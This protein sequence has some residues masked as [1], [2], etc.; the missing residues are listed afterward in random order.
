M[1]PMDSAAS[2]AAG[3]AALL[4]SATVARSAGADSAGAECF[5][6]GVPIEAGARYAVDIGGRARPMCCAGCQ[7]VAAAVVAAGLESYYQHRTARP[8]TAREALPELVRELAVYDHPD[9]QRTFVRAEGESVRE[10]WLLL[11]GI[12]CAACM[13]LNEQRLAALPGVMSVEA[14]YATHRLRVRW[15]PSRARLSGILRAVRELGYAA[16]PFDPLRQ[17]QMLEAERRD[18]LR[19]LGVAAVF[20]MQVMMLAVALYA[21]DWYGIDTPMRRFFERVS[22]LL[23]LPVL[24]YAARPFL[25]SA[26][27]DLAQRRVSMDVPV[28]TALLLAFAG[29]VWATVTGDGRVYYDSV[30]MFV[31]LLLGVRYLELGARRR[32]ANAADVLARIE[33]LLARRL[34]ESGAT[35]LVPA[36]E[37]RPEDRIV[38]RA[39]DT[40]AADGVII[41][42]RSS[43]DQSM[44]T[45]ESVP[46]PRGAGDRVIG[47]T[48]NVE[49]PLTVRVTHVG[50]DSVLADVQRLID[51]AQLDKPTV[52]TAA[53]RI[54][55]W[56]VAGV[57]GVAAAVAG[58]WLWLDP[59]RWL[60]V[61]I[62]VLVVSCPCA[63]SLA[64]PT[65]LTAAV[66]RL[67]AAGIILTRGRA[68]ETLARARCF[69]FDKTGTLTD[70]RLR[71]VNTVCLSDTSAHAC[72]RLAAALEQHSEHPVARALVAA[73]QGP[74]PSVSAVRARP[75][76]GLSGDIDGVRV[77][78]GSA[79]YVAQH[80]GRDP[81][82]GSDAAPEGVSTA[83]LATS[84]GPLCVFHLADRPRPTARAL[85]AGL[86]R[87]GNRVLLLS[88][89]SAAAAGRLARHVGIEEVC[90]GLSPEQK[91]TQVS[92]LQARGQVVAM[93]GDGVNDAPVLA[94]ASVSVAVSGAAPLAAVSADVVL[95]GSPLEA[96]GEAVA[97]AR[98]TQRVIR[99]NFAWALGYNLLAVPLAAAGFVVPLLAVVGMSLSSLLVVANAAR[100]RAWRGAR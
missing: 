78:L 29:S 18:G 85:V 10:A 19:R 36:V 56:F 48:L 17:Q 32:A 22:L 82:V 91:L 60:S 26:W 37:L 24:I 28:S 67:R 59:E 65:A 58:L 9:V 4:A 49:A 38:V 73:A 88:G 45:G 23:T 74:L 12:N 63:L 62:A 25:R 64:T 30:V 54:A 46:E 86:R 15:H 50:P 72:L 44:L 41:D 90:A 11:E 96:V 39:G 97:T 89:D 35:E 81:G 61:T 53:E 27:R 71:L 47:G 1:L 52:A 33:P 66:A 77:F 80:S 7:A 2:A 20:G 8:N 43:V 6:C 94:G 57:L 70:G 55:A 95:L 16:H 99:Q 69:V 100:L 76:Y 51:R 40:V 42:G 5:H 14:N 34:T 92:A 21:G 31:F 13:W 83:W 87:E 93:V 98:R 3:S 68:L 79:R 84:A 75:G